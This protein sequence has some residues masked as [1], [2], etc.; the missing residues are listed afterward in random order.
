MIE[1]FTVEAHGV[2]YK[3]RFI[4]P[5][6]KYL[7]DSPTGYSFYMDKETIDEYYLNQSS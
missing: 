7:V 2:E 4:E 1:K 6:N 3:V 5:I